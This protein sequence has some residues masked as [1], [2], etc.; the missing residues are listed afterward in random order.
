M[1]VIGSTARFE[2][3]LWQISSLNDLLFNLTYVL[4]LAQA[5]LLVADRHTNYQNSNRWHYLNHSHRLAKDENVA[6]HGVDDVD[7]ANEGYE[8]CAATLESDYL[9]HAAEGVKTRRAKHQKVFK[10]AETQKMERPRRE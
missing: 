6:E 8:A 2:N 9:A 10:G 1:V 5:D 3:I 4:D 7:E